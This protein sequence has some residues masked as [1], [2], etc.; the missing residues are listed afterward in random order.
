MRLFSAS[1]LA[2]AGALSLALSLG[3]CATLPAT[4]NTPF[5][6]AGVFGTYQDNDIG[7]INQ[8]AWAFASPANT[9]GNPIEAAR[10]IIAL[11]YLS[12]ELPENP[13]WVGMGST[14]KFRINEARGDLRHIVGIRPDAPPQLVVNALLA[15]AWDLQFG[16][17]TAALQALASPVFTQPPRVTLQALS[18]LPY[19]QTANLATV[20]AAE[21]EFPGGGVRG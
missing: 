1:P 2:L 13:R 5:L 19:V 9:R 3:A 21:V 15:L 20:R 14:I 12:G 17:Q 8:S 4:R 18:N 10:A 6:P 11:E 7:A 16:N